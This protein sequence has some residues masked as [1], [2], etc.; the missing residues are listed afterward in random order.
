MATIIN[1]AEQ[2][3][4]P[5]TYSITRTIPAN[6]TVLRLRI[7]LSDPGNWPEGRI[8][9]V[10]LIGP[11]GPSGGASFDGGI[12]RDRQG[13]IRTMRSAQFEMQGPQGES[14]PFPNGDYT[15][16]FD[17]LQTATSAVTVERF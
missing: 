1:R 6:A 8:A 9:D 3:Y 17:V 16:E 12:A 13:N 5:G 15:L 4:T 2:S 14:V 10:R 11:N 7:S